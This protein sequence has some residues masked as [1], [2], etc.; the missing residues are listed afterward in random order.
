MYSCISASLMASSPIA[1]RAL[2]PVPMPKS[3]RP[4][5]SLLSV[6]N[7]FA[8][9]PAM[10]FGRRQHA[11]AQA[12]A[13]SFHRRGRHGDKTIGTQHLRVVEPGVGEAEFFG[14]LH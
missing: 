12:N 2:K 8:V 3:M 4:G 1:R 6:A 14:A 9:T 10:R 7:A 13:R 11:G 5:A